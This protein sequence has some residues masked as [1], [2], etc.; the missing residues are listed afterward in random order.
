MTPIDSTVPS[1]ASAHPAFSSPPSV[2]AATTS[3]DPAPKTETLA[4]TV[5]VL[6]AAIDAGV[7]FLDTADMYGG[8]PGLSETLMGEALQGRRDRVVLATKFGHPGR[9]MGYATTASKGSRSYV[10]AAVEASLT[11][12]ADRLDRPLPAARARSGDARSRRRSRALDDLV[13]EGK[14]RYFGHSNLAGWQIAEADFTARGSRRPLRLRAEPLQPARARR[15]A[16]GAAGRRAVRSRL[17]PVL[18]AAQRPADRQVHA[19][20]AVPRAAAS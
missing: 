12:P 1:A 20:R 6:D 11:P 8:E 19:R 5:E 3:A 7:T 4:G 13:R 10:R 14:V 17:L 15:R 2:S 16:G 18:P 9:D